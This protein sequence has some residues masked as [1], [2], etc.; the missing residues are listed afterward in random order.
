MR[1]R[2]APTSSEATTTA[3]PTSETGP[4]LDEAVAGE[5]AAEIQED[6]VA[7]D[8]E[9]AAGFQGGLMPKNY[10]DTLSDEEL[11]ALATY[12]GEVAGK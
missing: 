7:P 8:K 5:D 6:I 11:E 12:L 3:V 1:S 4:N 9:I 10:G 2:P